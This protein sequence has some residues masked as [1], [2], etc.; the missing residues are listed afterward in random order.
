MNANDFMINENLMDE[1]HDELNGYN[2]QNID[3]MQQ[4]EE[5]AKEGNKKSSLKEQYSQT[6]SRTQQYQL[7]S[8]IA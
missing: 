1:A 6:V 7:M 8:Q 4:S 5:E 3:Q 2:Q